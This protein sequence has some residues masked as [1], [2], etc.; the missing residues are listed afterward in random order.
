MFADASSRL[1][2]VTAVLT[3]LAQAALCFPREAVVPRPV[4]PWVRAV[5]T[6]PD[7]L[8]AQLEARGI[9]AVG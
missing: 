9:G 5:F 2:H 4:E 7:G 8:R 1:E 6:R 3:A